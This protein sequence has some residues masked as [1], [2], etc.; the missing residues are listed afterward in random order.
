MTHSHRTFYPKNIWTKDSLLL[1]KTREESQSLFL[2]YPMNHIKW[3]FI[4]L[5][6][7]IIT[8]AILVTALR[9]NWLAW[10]S[11]WDYVTQK[12][13]AIVANKEVIW[14]QADEDK[15][16][17]LE[18]AKQSKP[19]KVTPKVEKKQEPIKEVKIDI[20]FDLDKLA[21]AVAIAETGNCT[22]GYG[23]TY[24]NCFWIKSGKTAP[25]PKVGKNKMCIYEKPEDS[26]IAFKKIWQR[27]YAWKPNLKMA[28][29]W[30]GHDNAV[31]WL[32]HVNLYYNK[33]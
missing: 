12:M 29:R 26:Y 4:L 13:P 19:V 16:I 32:S 14:S 31:R 8:L 24:S 15:R 18:H 20:S 2:I 28:Q 7:W 30:T 17:A 1:A 21:K 22:K 5:A 33:L 3:G 11:Y 27:W 23:K 10:V 25:C 6:S 9:A